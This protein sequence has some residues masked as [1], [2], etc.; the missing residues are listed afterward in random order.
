MGNE[1]AIGM[2]K[3]LAKTLSNLPQGSWIKR[4]NENCDDKIFE[5]NQAIKTL[6]DSEVIAEGIINPYEEL[7]GTER[8]KRLKSKKG[9]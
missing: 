9:E 8:E 3:D 2:L 6:Q 1:Y 7:L 5:L 4:Y